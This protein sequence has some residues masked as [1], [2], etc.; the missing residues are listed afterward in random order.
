MKNLNVLTGSGFL[1]RVSLVGSKLKDAEKK[2]VDFVIQNRE[3]IIHLS[4]TEVAERSSTSESTVVRLSKRL[5]YKG[6]QDLKINLAKEVVIPEK[7]IHEVIEP[8]DT[9]ST[10]KSKIFQSNIQALYDTLE[11][12]EDDELQ[13]AVQVLKKARE[14]EFYGTGASAAVGLDARHKFLKI[15]IKCS[16][17]LDVHQQLM[18]ASLLS[19]G[20]VAIGISHTG[21]NKDT[22]G[23]MKIAKE[24]G[25]T[26]ICITNFSKSPLTKLCDIK[27][28]TASNETF[29]R[30]DATASRIAQ[31]SII[32][33][34]LAGV[35]NLDY[36]NSLANIEKTRNATV[37]RRI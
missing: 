15:G 18:S 12:F 11:V 8:N 22:L 16:A 30:T 27:L 13:K 28:Y 4:I 3:E 25:A 26:L 32:D 9:L 7:Q 23:C 5:G 6:F 14:I 36:E 21:T 34:L 29:F 10:I 19:M 31:L 1:T 24:Q 35:A 17:H 33:T 2:V 20:D 37:D